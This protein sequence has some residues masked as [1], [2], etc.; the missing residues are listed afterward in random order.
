MAFTACSLYLMN[1]GSTDD[2]NVVSYHWEMVSGK[3]GS[4]TNIAASDLD[5]PMLVLKGLAPGSYRFKYV[6]CFDFALRYFYVCFLIH[7]CMKFP[8][9]F[10]V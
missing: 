6:A 5:K 10:S 7:S 1:A 9:N 4:Q 8:Q 3:L 2:D